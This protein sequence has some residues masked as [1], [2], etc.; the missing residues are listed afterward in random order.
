MLPLDD[1]NLAPQQNRIAI[2]SSLKLTTIPPELLTEVLKN[3][4]LKALL[5]VRKVCKYLSAATRTRAVWALLVTRYLAKP[6]HS[7]RLRLERPIDTYTSEELENLFLL[8]TSAR[9]GWSYFTDNEEK[10][11]QTAFD[12]GFPVQTDEYSSAHLIQGGRWMLVATRTGA[13][14][15]YDLDA[16]IITGTELIPPQTKVQRFSRTR[17]CVD[18]DADSP[19]L[20]FRFASSLIGH[21]P[22]A[23]IQLWQVDIKLDD[24]QRTIGLTATHLASFPLPLPMMTLLEMHL[25]GPTI[26]FEGMYYCA[27]YG[28]GEI[29]ISVMDWQRASKNP[30]D[31]AWRII[32]Q[33]NCYC[34]GLLPGNKILLNNMRGPKAYDWTR[35]EAKKAM[36]TQP[37]PIGRAIEANLDDIPQHTRGWCFDEDT[38]QFIYSEGRSLYRVV[39]KDAHSESLVSHSPVQLVDGYGEYQIDA[40]AVGRKCAAAVTVDGEV[41]LTRYA[42][43]K[44]L[45]LFYGIRKKRPSSL[46]PSVYRYDILM[47][48]AS[49]RI[50]LHGLPE[51]PWASVIDFALVRKP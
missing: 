10:D 18:V 47:D 25:L 32:D 45:E 42:L 29:Y 22:S 37:A 14:T 24:A 20:S 8:W 6:R 51:A 48:E 15:Y 36:P 31:Y 43:K 33:Q 2:L 4:P 19:M 13:V 23:S 3:L 40:H 46:H 30:P 39:V 34:V 17:M 26:A 35:L 50:V 44:Y 9:I 1:T 21:G 27:E 12:R 5:R 49:G 38:S 41:W 16:E 28:R 7:P 11:E